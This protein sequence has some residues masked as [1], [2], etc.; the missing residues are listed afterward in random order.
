MI[1]TFGGT[2]ALPTDVYLTLSAVGLDTL[3]LAE[4]TGDNS[5]RQLRREG[6]DKSDGRSLAG[7]LRIKGNHYGATRIWDCNFLVDRPQSDL[8]RLLLNHQTTS[9]QIIL[10]DNFDGAGA[11]INVFV[12]VDDRYL[13]QIAVNWYLLQFSAREDI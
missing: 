2:G 7:S 5:P 8:F 6:W 3:V 12:D 11:A 10:T 4:F 9:G 1:V 13:T